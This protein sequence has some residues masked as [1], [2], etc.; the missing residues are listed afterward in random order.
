MVDVLYVHRL[1]CQLPA[2][3]VIMAQ[4]Y[5]EREGWGGVGREEA[6]K[7]DSYTI[8][9][10]GSISDLKALKVMEGTSLLRQQCNI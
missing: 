3:V 4:V 2:S 8:Y 1:H 10:Y 5:L 9:T 7:G 6:W